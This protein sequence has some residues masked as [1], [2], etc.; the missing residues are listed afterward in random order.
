[1]SSFPSDN[2]T[3]HERRTG[4]NVSRT[5]VGQLTDGCLRSFADVEIGDL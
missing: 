4:P 2:G 5:P 1:L 3:A